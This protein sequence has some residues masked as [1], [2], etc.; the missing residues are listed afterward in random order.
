MVEFFFF[1]FLGGGGGMGCG[2]TVSIFPRV[3][4]FVQKISTVNRRTFCN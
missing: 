1:F 4:G 2:M 3:Y